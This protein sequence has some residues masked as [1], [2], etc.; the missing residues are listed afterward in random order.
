M[1]P[2]QVL[3]SPICLR[4]DV[5]S[6]STA[7]GVPNAARRALRPFAHG[8]P[9]GDGF[10]HRQEQ[11]E[12]VTGEPGFAEG[13]LYMIVLM[14][15]SSSG[16][17]VVFFSRFLDSTSKYSRDLWQSQF[18]STDL[19]LLLC[20]PLDVSGSPS[21]ITRHGVSWVLQIRAIFERLSLPAGSS[22]LSPCDPVEE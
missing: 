8:P 10:H 15:K 21:P 4:S 17:Y 12:S 3:C 19:G 5:L 6:P 13:D 18:P 11:V 1:Y 14:G 9:G 16:E 7:G 2:S 20:T 22:W